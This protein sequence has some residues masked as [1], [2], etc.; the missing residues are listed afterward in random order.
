[1]RKKFLFLFLLGI[2]GNSQAIDLQSLKDSQSY[3]SNINNIKTNSNTPAISG[4][5]SNY[6]DNTVSSNNSPISELN[7]LRS[8]GIDFANSTNW[9]DEGKKLASYLEEI[10]S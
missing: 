5:S 9:N 1:M 4:T 10:S 2:Y 8:K 6:N 7:E 3:N